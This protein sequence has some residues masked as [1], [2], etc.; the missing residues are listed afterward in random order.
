MRVITKAYGDEPL[1][2]EVVEATPDRVYVVNP[3]FTCADGLRANCG[4]GFRPETVF[5]FDPTL[6]ARLKAAYEAHDAAQLNDLW[7]K[8]AKAELC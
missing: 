7:S 8:A 1:E 4:V 5:R 3:S 6:L 2:R